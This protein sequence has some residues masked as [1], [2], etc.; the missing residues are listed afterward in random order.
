MQC[1]AL[2][3]GEAAAELQRGGAL[4]TN[5][6]VDLSNRALEEHG[7]GRGSVRGRGVGLTLLLLVL[8]LRRQRGLAAAICRRVSSRVRGVAIDHVEET[9]VGQLPALVPISCRAARLRVVVL[10]RVAPRLLLPRREV[11]G[12]P[13][14]RRNADRKVRPSVRRRVLDLPSRELG[15]LPPAVIDRLVQILVEE[16]AD[17]EAKAVPLEREVADLVTQL[18]GAA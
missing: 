1:L 2:P 16:R 7:G 8:L 3:R 18:Y 9:G 4:G 10:L 6:I 15:R 12:L 17:H 11:L 14:P 13:L 5:I